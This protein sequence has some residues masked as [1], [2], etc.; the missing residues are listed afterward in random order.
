MEFFHS[1]TLP[2][3]KQK[4]PKISRMRK[5]IS[6]VYKQHEEVANTLSTKLG[7]HVT[8]ELIV[9]ALFILLTDSNN[10]EILTDVWHVDI[11]YEEELN[12]LEEF[13]FDIFYKKVETSN[14]ILD[15]D[16]LYFEKAKIKHKNFSWFIHK[17]DADPFPSHPHAHCLSQNLKLDLSNGNCYRVRQYVDTIKKKDLLAIREK[18]EQVYQFPLPQISV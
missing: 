4:P 9:N 13:D 11:T 15:G 2:A 7:R 17:N 1:L 18:F 12:L 6:L 14:D 10:L 8:I 16:Y 5:D 3:T